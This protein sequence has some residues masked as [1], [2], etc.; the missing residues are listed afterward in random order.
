MVYQQFRQ[1]RRRQHMQT[2]LVPGDEVFTVGGLI[3]TVDRVEGNQL[4]L[5]IGDN[6]SVRVLRSAIGGKYQKPQ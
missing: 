6:V 5:R 3:G 2:E 4:V 1:Q